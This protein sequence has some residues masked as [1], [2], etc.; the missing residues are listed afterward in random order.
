[1]HDPSFTLPALY[2]RQIAD[3]VR[4]MGVDVVRW[5]A[6][7]NLSEA[8]LDDPAFSIAYPAFEGLVL[9]ALS[10]SGEPALGLLVGRRLLAN[11]HG[12]LGYAALSS[13][14]IRE[15]LDLVERFLH[16]RTSLATITH[17]LEGG[18]VRV[19]FLE[20]RP[21]GAIQRPVF[22]ALGLSLKNVVDAI[23]MGAGKVRR[24]AF[25]FETPDYAALA[26]ELFQ[27][28]VEY[29]QSWA[30]C[31]LPLGDIDVPLKMADP[32]AFREAERICQRE[33]DKLTESETFATRVTRLILEKQNGFPSLEVTARLFHMT[34]RTLHRRLLDEGTSFHQLLD[35][36]RHTLAVQHVRSGKLSIEEIAY[37]LGYSDL[38]NF[39]RAF[40]RWESVPPSE[41]RDKQG[42]SQKHLPPTPPSAPT[43]K[44]RRSPAS[45]S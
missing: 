43:K 6:R 1:M 30:G 10:M 23:S 21:L 17:T 42:E 11:S 44:P 8:A 28:D 24:V 14:T 32:E 5:L 7:S 4:G 20:T 15:A 27:C 36:V 34:P 29:G 25:P 2:I 9:D 31:I 26:R 41:Y 22:E 3:V 13:G 33:L 37:V 19:H 45:R 35:D 38:A 16:V 12:I 40:K 39:R 18:E